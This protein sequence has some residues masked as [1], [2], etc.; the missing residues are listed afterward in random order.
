MQCHRRCGRCARAFRAARQA[1]NDHAG[2]VL[3]IVLALFALVAAI[4]RQYVHFDY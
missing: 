2:T 1:I 4:W 3:L